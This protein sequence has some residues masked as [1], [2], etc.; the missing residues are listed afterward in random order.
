M[1]LEYTLHRRKSMIT[2]ELGEE[3][4][5]MDIAVSKDLLSLILSSHIHI[6]KIFVSSHRREDWDFR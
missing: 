4:D 6:A 3:N 5:A 1:A 2:D